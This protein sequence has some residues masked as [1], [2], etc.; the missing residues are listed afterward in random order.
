MVMGWIRA[1]LSFVILLAALLCVHG[2]WTSGGAW[3]YRMVPLYLS[4]LLINSFVCF[5]LVF[6]AFCVLCVLWCSPVFIS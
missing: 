1:C 4:L 3:R 2:N 6:C 5:V